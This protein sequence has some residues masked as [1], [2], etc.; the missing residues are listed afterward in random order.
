MSKATII[1]LV[2]MAALV[3]SASAERNLQRYL[4]QV[5]F[6]TGHRPLIAASC[7]GPT[8]LSSSYLR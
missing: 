7:H 8:L 2:L 4:Q 1:A 3:A 6:R 5:G